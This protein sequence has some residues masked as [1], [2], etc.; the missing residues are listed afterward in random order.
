MQEIRDAGFD[1]QQDEW[2]AGVSSIAVPVFGAG[3]R[4]V[5]ALSVSPPTIRFEPKP[6]I[7]PLFATADGLSVLLK[8]MAVGASELAGMS[9]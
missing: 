7:D 6:W 1:T 9:R 3:D 2:S 4:P 8:S 5:A